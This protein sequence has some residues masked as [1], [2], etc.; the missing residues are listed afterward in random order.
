[1]EQHILCTLG[2][3]IGHISPT[4]TARLLSSAFFKQQDVPFCYDWVDGY[5]E[6]FV[7]LALSDPDFFSY[8]YLEISLSAIFAFLDILDDEE[9]RSAFYDWLITFSS[10]NL[11]L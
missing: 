9:Y 5:F 11:V 8:N 10:F 3:E 6:G 7:I 1:M 2:W 4:E